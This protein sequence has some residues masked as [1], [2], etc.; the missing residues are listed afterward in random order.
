MRAMRGVNVVDELHTMAA[1]TMLLEVFGPIIIQRALIWA[2]RSTGVAP[3][4]L[5]LS[6]R[7]RR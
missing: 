4:P 5:T 1:V 2:Q 7:P 3:C 6:I